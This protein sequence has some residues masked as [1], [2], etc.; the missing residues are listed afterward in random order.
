MASNCNKMKADNKGK[1]ESVK[2]EVDREDTR[3]RA[4]CDGKHRTHTK[5]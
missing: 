4:G 1:P 3:T 2:T 5:L